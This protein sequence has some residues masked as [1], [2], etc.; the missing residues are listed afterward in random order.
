MT[1]VPSGAPGPKCSASRLPPVDAVRR[2]AHAQA[3]AG[4][5]LDECGGLGAR[6]L[7]ARVQDEAVSGGRPDQLGG[8]T[9]GRRG[10]APSP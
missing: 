7:G 5:G 3:E 9:G 2:G 8:G 6:R 1:A 10:V 4:R